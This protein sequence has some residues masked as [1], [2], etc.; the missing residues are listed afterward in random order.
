MGLR[1]LFRRHKKGREASPCPS[2]SSSTKSQQIPPLP[3]QTTE[4][5]H[6]KD[7]HDKNLIT[8]LDATATV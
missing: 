7:T 1:D 6:Q 4:Q 3:S 8:C 2:T 5:K